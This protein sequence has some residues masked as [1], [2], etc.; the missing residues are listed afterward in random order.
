MSKREQVT[1][2]CPY[3][4]NEHPFTMWGSINTVLDPQMKAA[5]RD[6]SAFLFECPTCGEK[7]YVDY[8]MLY[9]QMEDRIM[10]HYV[11]SD[12]DAQEAYKLYMQE[13]D[14]DSLGLL[15]T[16]RE[17]DYLIRI[18]RSQSEMREKIAIFDAGLDDRIIEMIKLFFAA[19]YQIDHPEQKSISVYYRREG[20]EDLIEV[21]ADDNYMGA[22]IFPEGLY[23]EIQKAYLGKIPEMRKDSP[24][25]NRQWAMKYI[26]TDRK[27]EE[28]T[29]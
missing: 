24:F 23:E 10:I 8:S 3:C 28:T 2:T 14:S 25:I 13:D 27:K 21:Y 7:T 19:K 6:R 26:E 4:N 5:V 22:M 29:V 9:H 20:E 12:E 15:Q 16:M 17:D 18:V 11:N 1:V